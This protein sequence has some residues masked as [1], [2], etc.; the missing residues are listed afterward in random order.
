MREQHSRCVPDVFGE[1]PAVGVALDE[2]VLVDECELIVEDAAVLVHH[3]RKLAYRCEQRGVV[4]V[5]VHDDRGVGASSMQLGVDRDGARDVPVAL[6]DVAVGVD[7][8]DLR[9]AD[10]LP[11]D[12]PRV[13]PHAAVGHGPRDVTV[14]VLAPALVGEDA[15]RARELL[16]NGQLSADARFG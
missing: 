14:E 10:L 4:G 1:P 11:P 2:G 8:D 15:Q 5:V 6:D 16:R 13:H 12:A 9:G 3:A 7:A